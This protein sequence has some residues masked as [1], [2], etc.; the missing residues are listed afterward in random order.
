MAGTAAPI[1]GATALPKETK[2]LWIRAGSAASPWPMDGLTA[3]ESP[4]KFPRPLP[5][6]GVGQADGAGC[7]VLFGERSPGVQDKII[8]RGA[9]GA[10]RVAGQAQ[11]VGPPVSEHC[12]A[13]W[14]SWQGGR[15]GEDCV[16][17]SNDKRLV[18]ER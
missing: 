7:S 9:G 17:Q 18:G 13:V 4:R 12:Q 5:V 16:R 15:I 14:Q 2:S 6:L 8:G 10:G 3:L 1:R 11:N